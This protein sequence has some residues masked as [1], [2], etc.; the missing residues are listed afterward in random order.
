MST[1]CTETLDRTD[2]AAYRRPLL[3]VFLGWLWVMAGV[4]LAAPLYAV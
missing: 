3:T 1:A 2:R 4:N